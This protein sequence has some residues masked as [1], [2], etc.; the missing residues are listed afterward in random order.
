MPE[1]QSHVA[2]LEDLTPNATVRSLLTEGQSLLHQRCPG[3]PTCS[4]RKGSS[5]G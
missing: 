1:E 2:R 4:V 5:E 3:S